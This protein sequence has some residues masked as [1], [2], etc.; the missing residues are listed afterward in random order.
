MI[1]NTR[2]YITDKFYLPCISN[3]CINLINCTKILYRLLQTSET[4][5]INETLSGYSLCVTVCVYLIKHD[6]LFDSLPANIP[7][8]FC[9]VNLQ[10]LL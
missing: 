4:E 3:L 1:D 7:R 2:E 8:R 6:Y 10:F 9:Y 5:I